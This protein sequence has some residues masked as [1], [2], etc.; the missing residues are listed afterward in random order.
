VPNVNSSPFKI[1]ASRKI[2]TSALHLPP[3]LQALSIE[4]LSL[5]SLGKLDTS[6]FKI[7]PPAIDTL[8]AYKPIKLPPAS[9]T[10]PNVNSSPFKD[11]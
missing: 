7:N 4:S 2:D 5:P 6:A 1:D 11:D 8:S 9:Q 3:P 10:L